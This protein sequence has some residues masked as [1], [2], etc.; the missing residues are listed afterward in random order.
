M[1]TNVFLPKKE[2]KEVVQ[3]QSN[4]FIN[5]KKHPKINH[6]D[7]P[8]TANMLQ[9]ASTSPKS[10]LQPLPIW[11]KSV[12][13]H[14]SSNFPRSFH[15]RAQFA[16]KIFM[17]LR[18]GAAIKVSKWVCCAAAEAW[19]PTVCAAVLLPPVDRPGDIL[20]HFM[21]SHI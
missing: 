9:K 15:T 7:T 6:K 21:R 17:N 19:A 2:R 13:N 10:P 11:T 18:S 14:V 4:A 16:V 1:Q 12:Y 5:P 20:F 8:F 3:K